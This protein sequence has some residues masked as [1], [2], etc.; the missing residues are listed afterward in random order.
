MAPVLFHSAHGLNDTLGK[1]FPEYALQSNCSLLSP[2]P[3]PT[4]HLT[5]LY[6]LLTSC[7]LLTCYP[8][9]I[10]LFVLPPYT[11][12]F[13]HAYTTHLLDLKSGPSRTEHI[14]KS[15][16][17][18]PHMSNNSAYAVPQAGLSSTGLASELHF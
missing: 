16:K 11:H 3:G 17:S 7:H 8:C 13:T 12:T 9:F 2:S 18:I 1:T 6:S 5:H 15:S 10:H 4:S 14:V